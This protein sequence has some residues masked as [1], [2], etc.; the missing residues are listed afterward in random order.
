MSCVSSGR[1]WSEQVTALQLRA[2][3]EQFAAAHQE[4]P[5]RVI[6]D[7]QDMPWSVHYHRRLLHWVLRLEP[8]ASVPLL[9]SA[10]CQHIRRWSIP[11]RDYEEG[12]QGYRRWRR[13]LA[14]FHA[15]EAGRVLRKVGYDEETIERVGTLL[16]KVGLKRNPEVQTFEDAICMVFLETE[17]AEFSKKHPEHKMVDIIQRTWAKMS[18]DGH[19]MALELATTLPEEVRAL[20]ERALEP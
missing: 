9:L 19:R 12:R 14:I 20:L 15:D 18:Q 4:D 8:E 2:A 17:L 3:E 1:A 13:E 7:G 5:R 10:Q 11:R 16:R 6:V